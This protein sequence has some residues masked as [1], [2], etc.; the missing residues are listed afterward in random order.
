MKLSKMKYILII[1]VFTNISNTYAQYILYSDQIVNLEGNNLKIIQVAGFPFGAGNSCP[2]LDSINI[3]IN[4]LNE[5]SIN[6]F[7]D[8][9]GFWQHFGCSRT[10]SIKIDSLTSQNYSIFVK[11]HLITNTDTLFNQDLDTLQVIINNDYKILRDRHLL[12]YPNPV[13]ECVNIETDIFQIQEIYLYDIQGKLM[14]T[15][16][17]NERRVNLSSLENG[18]Y[19]LRVKTD[20]GWINRKIIK[21]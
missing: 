10:D 2:Q 20:V 6:L 5:I 1:L 8:I 12:T 13:I 21:Q 19:I 17:K 9:R 3:D 18:I 11:T 14:K 15:V 4:N 16:S 7:Y